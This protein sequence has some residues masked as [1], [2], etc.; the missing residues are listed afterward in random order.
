MANGK[1]EL[2]SGG[3]VGYVSLPDHP[4]NGAA[5]F[6]VR[7]VRLHDLYPDYDGPDIYFDLDKDN[8]LLGIEILL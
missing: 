5:G 1:I 8:R 4:G 7:Q 3:K 6:V 2:R